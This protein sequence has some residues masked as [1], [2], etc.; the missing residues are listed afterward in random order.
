[1][2]R[3]CEELLV[4]FLRRAGSSWTLHLLKWPAGVWN[5]NNGKWWWRRIDSEPNGSVQEW[6]IHKVNTVFCFFFWKDHLL[7]LEHMEL[8]SLFTYNLNPTSEKYPT[9]NLAEKKCFFYCLGPKC[10]LCSRAGPGRI[11]ES[12][13]LAARLKVPFHC[14]LAGR[15]EAQGLFYPVHQLRLQVTQPRSGC[16]CAPETRLLCVLCLQKAQSFHATVETRCPACDPLLWSPAWLH[17]LLLWGQIDT[18]MLSPQRTTHP[19][20]GWA[21]C[22]S[23][24]TASRVHLMGMC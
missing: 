2:S 21:E 18:L 10:P 4:W 8:W 3:M 15:T 7:L 19:L 5:I 24:A 6:F 9:L 13:S 12:G 17:L 14:D 1:M 11:L 16:V 22:V 20:K 23:A